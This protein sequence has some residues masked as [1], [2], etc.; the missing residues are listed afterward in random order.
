MPPC[1]EPP[2]VVK[3]TI[4]MDLLGA[5]EGVDRDLL[6]LAD[7]LGEARRGV[8]ERR[9]LPELVTEPDM[10]MSSSVYCTAAT[11][12]L[13]IVCFDSNGETSLSSS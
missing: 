1:T 5:V 4:G 2:P 8:G 9:R 6:R 12:G 13:R 10:S 3:P 7:A 11:S